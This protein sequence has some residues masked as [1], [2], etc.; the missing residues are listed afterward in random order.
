MDLGTGY[1]NLVMRER[2]FTAKA[3]LVDAKLQALSRRMTSVSASA[4]RMLMIGGAIA[5]GSVRALAT[6]EKQLSMVSTMLDEQ[7]MKL[8]PQYELAMKRMAK[9][10]G[11]GTKTISKGLYDILSASVDASKALDVLEVSIKAARAG[12]STTAISADAITTILNAYGLEAER[13]GDVSDLLF[14]IVKRG[15]ITFAE[16]SSSIGQVASVAAITGLSMEELGASI[17][18]LTRTGLRARITMTAL[19]SLISQFLTP[20]AEASKLAWEEFGLEINTTTLKAIGLSGVLEKLRGATAEQLAVII[21]NIR[22]YVGLA[23]A[24]QNVEGHTTDLDLMLNRTGKTQ[25]AYEK[26]TENLNHKLNQLWQSIKIMAVEVGDALAP[27]I[28]KLSEKII[29][30]T[31]SISKWVS[32]NGDAISSVTVMTAKIAILVIVVEKLLKVFLALKAIL[33][34]MA[35]PI[36]IIIALA[37][38]V[39][40]SLVYAAKKIGQAMGDWWAETESGEAHLKAI[41]EATDE[42]AKANKNLEN[43]LSNLRKKQE[44][45][46]GMKGQQG[47]LEYMKKQREVLLAS[48][49]ANR[50]IVE[51]SKARIKL[52][53]QTHRRY[54][55]IVARGQQ[56]NRNIDALKQQ[57]ILL[58]MRIKKEKLYGNEIRKR[59][60]IEQKLAEQSITIGERIKDLEV[61]ISDARGDANIEIIKATREYEKQLKVLKD[62]EEKAAKEMGGIIPKEF[63]E[64]RILLHELLQERLKAIERKRLKDVNEEEKRKAEELVELRKTLMTD[65]IRATSGELEAQLHTIEAEYNELA[66]KFKGDAQALSML[67]AVVQDKVQKLMGQKETRPRLGFSDPASLWK[68]MAQ[69]LNNAGGQ[70]TQKKLLS[71]FIQD[72]RRQ[73]R[74]EQTAMRQREKSI[75]FLR[76]I[77]DKKEGSLRR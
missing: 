48:V 58:D 40:T 45:L 12:F 59:R 15:K 3:T 62:A 9:V 57:L 56:A 61:Q 32:K 37:T 27:Q 41:T 25:E 64:E 65:Y 19:R 33:A 4:K 67:E 31:E 24:L 71:E 14:A 76:K 38:A 1:I 16:L 21:P 53:S 36:M 73:E 2:Q 55:P 20:S 69:S 43:S 52:A 54:K 66:K 26:T 39:A 70:D 77:S 29:S 28:E 13:A 23:A 17:A 49:E 35:A 34:V 74:N 30:V 51:E 22:G 44:E 8:M 72:S 47:T 63:N 46:R 6:F 42:Y 50:K 7:S 10:Y 60:I 5:F 18:T 75:E 11:E 68:S